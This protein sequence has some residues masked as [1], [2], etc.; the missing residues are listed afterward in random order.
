MPVTPDEYRRGMRLIPSGVT[1]ITTG[2]GDA[3]AGLTATAVMSLTA[4]PPQLVCAVNRTVSAHPAIAANGVVCI[5]LLA[6]DQDNIG[7]RFAGVGGVRGA[8]RFKGG[9][10]S[11]LVTGAPVLQGAVASFDCRVVDRYDFQTHS[12]FVCLVEAVHAAPDREP[13]LYVNGSW[14]SLLPVGDD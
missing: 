4:E 6:T 7:A 10:W 1:V 2:Q 9:R 11:T 14:A 5:N 12:L 8:E 13:L 3:R